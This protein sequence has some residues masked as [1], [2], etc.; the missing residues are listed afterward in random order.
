MDAVS[1]AGYPTANKISVHLGTV[2]RGQ[3]WLANCSQ[4]DIAQGNSL[5]HSAAP[6]HKIIS[7]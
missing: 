4:K 7:I 2:S 3:A 5:K 1:A 6:G